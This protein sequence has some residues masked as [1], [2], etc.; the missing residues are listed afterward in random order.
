MLLTDGLTDLQRQKLGHAIATLEGFC[1]TFGVG[2]FGDVFERWVANDDLEAAGARP[3]RQTAKLTA[4]E[5]LDQIDEVA[6][7]CRAVHLTAA[8][9]RYDVLTIL[10]RR[11]AYWQRAYL[12]A[13]TDDNKLNELDAAFR[14]DFPKLVRAI[15]KISG[16]TGDA[17]AKLFGVAPMK[18]SRYLEG[19]V[20]HRRLRPEMLSDMHT[21]VI[22][23]RRDAR[24][25]LEK[26]SVVAVDGS[27]Q[28]GAKAA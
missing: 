3:T 21:L 28:G 16:T 19:S 7:C 13:G 20:P 8:K 12:S 27:T 25:L 1:E 24:E 9:A 17:L 11:I 14:D 10:Q 6:D 4:S 18:I 23:L 26:V 22:S 2:K 15:H 5:V